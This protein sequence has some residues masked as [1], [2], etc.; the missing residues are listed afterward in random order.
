[1]STENVRK[2]KRKKRPE[3]PREPNAFLYPVAEGLLATYL[4]VFRHQKI[5]RSAVKDLKPPFV[6]IGNHQ[7][8]WDFCTV[9]VCCRQA[10]INF[11]V[12]AHFF[13]SPLLSKWLP[14]GGCISK[15]QFYP[16]LPAVRQMMRVIKRGGVVGI[17][18]EG[19]TCVSGENNEVE[20][21]IGRLLKSLGVPVVNVKIRG[22][23][24]AAP[25]WAS[26]RVT[27]GKSSAVA[28]ILIDGEEIRTLTE[29]QI[30]DRVIEGLTYDEYEWQR[31]VMTANKKRSLDGLERYLWLCPK[32][33]HE[34][35]FSSKDNR[36]TCSHCG[37]EVTMDPYG[38]LH[39]ENGTVCD[40]PSGWIRWQASVLE[41]R[42]EEGTALPLE[43]DGIWYESALGEYDY[44]GYHRH[45]EGHFTLDR[46]GLL[47]VGKR[48]GEDFTFHASPKAQWN[49][50]HSYEAAA[51]D[52]A[53]DPAQNRDYS[54]APEEP[55][56]MLK[57]IQLWPLIRK[58]WYE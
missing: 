56:M 10:R 40:T 17:F 21:S 16:D 49:L 52:F 22:N 33:G 32:C 23:Y 46:D 42:M 4:R 53:G 37:L 36:M 7:S 12:S 39:S 13:R 24:L 44:Y 3:N 35:T 30:A 15:K 11:V 45:G 26:G 29:D 28:E 58:K 41:Q 2:E 50:T 5:D 9:G 54:I 55:R 19:Q 18:P 25:K 8:M 6:V 57:M 43:G 14:V 20:R 47:F 27:P 1:M 48:D 38:F 51:V 34:Y 31:G